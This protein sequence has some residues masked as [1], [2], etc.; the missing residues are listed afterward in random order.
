MNKMTVQ[1][2]RMILKRPHKFHSKE[3]TKEDSKFK[4]LSRSC[5]SGLNQVGEL[6]GSKKCMHLKSFSQRNREERNGMRDPRGFV[7]H[8]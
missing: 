4:N 2:D 5:N 1:L 8:R 3:D 6:L 7:R